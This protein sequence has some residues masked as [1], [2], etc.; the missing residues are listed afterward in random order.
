MKRKPLT[1]L[2]RTALFD[3]AHGICCLCDLPIRAGRGEMWVEHLKPLW[4]G[5]ADDRSNMGPAHVPCARA[6]TSGEAPQKAKSD[7]V[8]ANYLGIRKRP[9]GRPL[10]GTRASGIRRRMNGN[11][12]R[13]PNG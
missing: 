3:A 12:E 2:Q 7:R 9:R 10:A 13:W 5:G 8:R 1:R 6:K 4:L 11:V